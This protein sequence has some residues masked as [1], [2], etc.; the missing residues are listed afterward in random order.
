[1]GLLTVTGFLEVGQFWPAGSSDADTVRIKLRGA[2]PFA[3]Q[4]DSG[5]SARATRA[6]AG[7][8]V[9]VKGLKQMVLGPDGTLR[10]RLQGVD[11]PELHYRPASRLKE[12]RQHYAES[13]T[14]ALAGHLRRLFGRDRL[15]CRLETLVAEPNDVFDMY[16]RFIG[17]VI[18]A[19]DGEDLNLNQWLVAQGWAVPSFYNSMTNEEIRGL[20]KLAE[21]AR[22]AQAGVWRRGG[23]TSVLKDLDRSLTY[24]KPTGGPEP[25]GGPL[26]LPKLF[27][28]QYMWRDEQ[29]RGTTRAE[30]LRDYLLEPS[31]SKRDKFVDAE[32]FLAKRENAPVRDLGEAIRSDNR[33]GLRPERIVFLEA[34]ANLYGP[35]GKIVRD[36]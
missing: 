32:K 10:V 7:A 36:W 25:D 12:L 33:L 23:Y 16:A 24:R 30:T 35:D 19:Q 27:R 4:P 26:I 22:K 1:M 15:E 2:A 31:P 8:F 21:Q 17:D 18:V 3:F 13:A 29:D 34:D 5:A 6:F 28:R 11:A 14:S 9:R 20:T